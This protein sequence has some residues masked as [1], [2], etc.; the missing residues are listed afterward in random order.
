MNSVLLALYEGLQGTAAF[1]E[2]LARHELLEPFTLDVQL[3]DGSRI[4]L[5]GLYTIAE[6]RL[7]ALDG[8][9]LA[10]LSRDGHLDPIYIAVA[11]LSNLRHLTER[12]NRSYTGDRRYHHQTPALS[13][14]ACSA[15]SRLVLPNHD[16][17]SP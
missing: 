10:R 15:L 14:R 17:H 12:Q 6:E 2:A 9:A 1:I 16:T 13:R 4:T 11:S 3:D 5:A 7:R 8:D